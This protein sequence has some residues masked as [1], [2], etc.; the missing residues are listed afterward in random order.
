MIGLHRRHARVSTLAASL[1]DRPT[2][3]ILSPKPA[4]GADF[5]DAARYA[6]RDNRMQ[7]TWR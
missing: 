6:S 3:P 7:P 5:D 4:T 2:R 1:D